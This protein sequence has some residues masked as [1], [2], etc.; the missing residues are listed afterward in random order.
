MIGGGAPYAK[1]TRQVLA[2]DIILL[3]TPDDLISGV[4]A[5]LAQIGGEEWR[6][7]IALH[8]SGALDRTVLS[9]LKRCGAA[10][11]SLH[12][13]QTFSG[14]STP[15]L[16][17]IIFGVE[18]EGGARGAARQIARA[19]GGVPVVIEGRRKP[20]YHAAGAFVASLGLGVVE[21]ATRILMELG[22]TRRHAARAL[23]PLARQMLD[24]FERLGPRVSWTGPLSR[25][26]YATV[27]KHLRALQRYPREFQE[28]YTA[29]ARLAGRVLPANPVPTLRRLNRMTQKYQGGKE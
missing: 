13:M 29:L 24:N 2:A 21:A 1:L 6:G 22:F 18:G 16:E 5:E 7:K 23:L 27:E 19:L 12:P 17:G 9:K 8:T 14:R 25:G 3:A 15:R 26:D 28:A 4:A 11:G 10:T 20:E